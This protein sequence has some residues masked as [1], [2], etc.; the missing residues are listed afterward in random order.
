MESIAHIIAALRHGSFGHIY[1]AIATID[2]Q[3]SIDIVGTLYNACCTMG[4]RLAEGND[5]SY[6]YPALPREIVEFHPDH[7]PDIQKSLRI[8]PRESEE[9]ML[10]FIA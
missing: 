5:G 2:E 8:G 10:G 6:I 9:V 4:I 3:K 7:Y 1:G